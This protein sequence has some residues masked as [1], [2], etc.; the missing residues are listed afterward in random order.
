MFPMEHKIICIF[1]YMFVSPLIFLFVIGSYFPLSINPFRYNLPIRLS[2]SLLYWSVSVNQYSSFPEPYKSSKLFTSYSS[3]WVRCHF[4][5]RS[6][7]R[8]TSAILLSTYVEASETLTIEVCLHFFCYETQNMEQLVQVGP[9]N[10]TAGFSDAAAGATRGDVGG[11]AA[12]AT[13][14]VGGFVAAGRQGAPPAPDP[15]R[16]AAPAAAAAGAQHQHRQS[17]AARQ[18]PQWRSVLRLARGNNPPLK[19]CVCNQCFLDGGSLNPAYYGYGQSRSRSKTKQV[20]ISWDFYIR[21]RL[22]HPRDITSSR[23]YWPLSAG[24]E[25]LHYKTSGYII[26]P[27]GYISHFER[28]E[29][30]HLRA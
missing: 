15:V 6:P 13:A 7:V 17:A 20:S 5:I 19:F 26:Q 21:I 8:N 9:R 10:I 3:S 11:A 29:R 4:A 16:D 1:V 28:C 23:L 24:T 2:F 12:A 22:Y 18:Q 30:E 27:S 14:A 25:C